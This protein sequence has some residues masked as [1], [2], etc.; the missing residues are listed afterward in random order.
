MKRLSVTPNSSET[1]AGMGYLIFQLMFLGAVLYVVNSLLP[2]P[3]S[4][5]QLNCAAFIINF[6]CVLLIFRKFLWKNLQNAFGSIWNTLRW[7]A[8]G[9]GFYYLGNMVV[10]ILIIAVNPSFSNVNDDSIGQMVQ[11]SYALMTICTVLLVPIVEETLYRGLVFG[12]LYKKHPVLA[13][14]ISTAFF[15]AVHVVG[16]VDVLTPGALVLSF[17]Q[18]VPAGLS[19]AWAYAQSDSIWASILIHMINNQLGIL[20]A[21]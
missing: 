9:F 6:I 7:S 1:A 13:Y 16:Y 12:T 8:A 5:T 11:Q 2:K 10:S 3:M 14:I 21:R 17:L 20:L 19:L 18:Y 4:W 15:A